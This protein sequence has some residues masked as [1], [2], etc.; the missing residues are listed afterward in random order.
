MMLGSQ[1]GKG[2]VCDFYQPVPPKPPLQ[3]CR[4]HWWQE[5]TEG[6]DGHGDPQSIAFLQQSWRIPGFGSEKG[7][8][9][10]LSNK[11]GRPS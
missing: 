2:G 8:R 5:P 11:H 9:E 4:S 10:E 6:S 3:S 1:D 7:R